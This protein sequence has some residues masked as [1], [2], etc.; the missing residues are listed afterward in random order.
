MTVDRRSEPGFTLVEMLVAISLLGLLGVISWRGLDE[1]IAQRQ[2]IA[3]QTTETQRLVRA[4]GQIERDVAQRVPNVLFA[5]IRASSGQ[6]PLS[7]QVVVEEDGGEQLQI[8]R[9]RVDGPGLLAV[10]YSLEEG[11][12]VRRSGEEAEDHVIMLAGVERFG[13][14]L[15]AGGE[16]LDPGPGEPLKGGVPVTAMEIA[17]ERIGGERYVLVLAL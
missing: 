10:S 17:V 7:I 5:T 9:T 12:L 14:R 1:I 8:I 3:T 13:L 15:L 4:F 11:D 16:W 6:L 2:R